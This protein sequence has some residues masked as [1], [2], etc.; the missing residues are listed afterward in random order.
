MQ[1]FSTKY[2]QT[3]SN[4]VLKGLY[5]MIK[6]NLSPKCKDFSIP[7]NHFMYHINKLNKN[8]LIILIDVEKAFG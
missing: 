5:I 4:N 6:C 3:E 8:P 7:A 2:Q 1:K